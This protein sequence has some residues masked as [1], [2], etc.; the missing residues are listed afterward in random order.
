VKAKDYAKRYID[1]PTDKELVEIGR[2]FIL[3]IKSITKL[4]NVKTNAGLK[5]IV[6]ELDKKW[7]A[8]AKEVGGGIINPDGFIEL[9][10]YKFGNIYDQLMEEQK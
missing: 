6:I 7:K 9:L 5:S 2:D 4:R 8:F 1:N 10:K 3:E